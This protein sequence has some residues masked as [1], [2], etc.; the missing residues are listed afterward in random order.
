MFLRVHV[1]LVL[2]GLSLSASE[3]CE[4][5]LT[6]LP[7]DDL[8][9]L[10]GRWNFIEGFTDHKLFSDILS[11]VDS[12]WI[13]I[14]PTPSNNFLVVYEFNKINGTC[15]I[16]T[17]NMTLTGDKTTVTHAEGVS[18]VK[19]L[20]SCS[21]CVTFSFVS[22]VPNAAVPIHS[23]YVLGRSAVLE[24][25]ELVDFR[26]QAECLHFSQPPNFHYDAKQDFCAKKT[27]ELKE[28]EPAENVS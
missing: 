18:D 6:P 8:S 7:L 19:I 9:K 11:V 2:A 4:Q 28:E 16:S 21:R 3:D 20:P 22:T 5:L 10:F 23:L 12:S 27:E 26:K 1:F 15:N 24:E 14:T 25:S 17:S 13:D